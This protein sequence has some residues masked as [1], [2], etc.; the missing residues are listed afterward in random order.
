[1]GQTAAPPSAG[2]ELSGPAF[3][4]DHI[5]RAGRGRAA[6][7]GGA[8]PGQAQRAVAKFMDELKIRVG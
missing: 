3:N 4:F 1:M 6:D 7:V 5:R 8:N 2:K